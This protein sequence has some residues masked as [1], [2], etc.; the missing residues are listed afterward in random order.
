MLEAAG[1]ELSEVTKVGDLKALIISRTG[2]IPTN[3]NGGDA[4]RAEAEA[5]L[6]ASATTLMPDEDLASASVGGSCPSCNKEHAA[7]QLTPDENGKL[8]C[9]CGGRV[10]FG[11]E[12]ES[13]EP[14]E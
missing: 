14:V 11:D 4:L 5:A 13:A 2:H 9:E 1:G 12:A 8:W 7:G 6:D 10:S 3:K